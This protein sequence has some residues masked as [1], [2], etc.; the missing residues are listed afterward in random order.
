MTKIYSLICLTV[1]LSCS[2]V[3]ESEANY[4]A[5]NPS[6]HESQYD[7]LQTSSGLRYYYEKKG[8][9]KEI[10]IGSKVSTELSLSIDGKVVWTS[11]S[12]QNGIFSFVAGQGTV[13]KGFD[14]M[15]LLLREGDEVVAIIPPHIGYGDKGAGAMVPPN[16]TLVYDKFKVVKVE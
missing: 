4:S 13:I 5:E 16:A 9:G 12:M 6:I 11:E 8:K 15:A 2:A 7:T 14:E 3:S 1:L 10:E